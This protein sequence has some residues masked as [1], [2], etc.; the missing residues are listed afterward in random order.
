GCLQ[1][2]SGVLAPPRLFLTTWHHHDQGHPLFLQGLPRRNTQGQCD[3]TPAK[4][5]F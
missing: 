1:A 3:P 4:Q 5:N 2:L